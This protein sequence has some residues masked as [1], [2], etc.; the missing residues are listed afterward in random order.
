VTSAGHAVADAGLRVVVSV[1]QR[2]ERSMWNTLPNCFV[3]HGKL[4]ITVRDVGRPP[5]GAAVLVRSA[6]LLQA[7][8]LVRSAVLLQAA[9]KT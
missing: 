1:L 8:G 3:V 4:L 9:A 7:A 2:A 5:M 6:V